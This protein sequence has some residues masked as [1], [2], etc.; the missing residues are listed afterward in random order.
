MRRLTAL[1]STTL[2][3]KAVVAVTGILFYGFVLLHMLGNLKVFTGNVAT[4]EP[5]I[6]VY[7]AFLRTM[8]EP[9]VP[10][11]FILWC[12]RIVLLI[13]L[14]LHV[15]TVLQ[16]AARN[17][18]ARDTQYA[19]HQYNE[20]SVPA[21][22]MLVSGFLLLAFLVF[23]LLQFTFGVIGVTRFEQEEV[24]SNLYYAFQK[25]FFVLIYVVAMA[26]LA[27]HVNHGI[28]SLFQTLGLDN[29]DRNRAFRILA[30]AS[31]IALFVGFSSVPVLFFLGE[32]PP[33]PTAEMAA[34]LSGGGK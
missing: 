26:A 32:M 12:V 11:S 30:T 3:K 16:L 4:G 24:Y 5:H 22:L 17:R 29:P 10:Y 34:H 2:G 1:Y 20:S 28:W 6:D 25:W 15:V 14:I 27:L 7:A 8:G 9:L 21:R 23:H 31:A 33:P 18:N 19:R 13:A